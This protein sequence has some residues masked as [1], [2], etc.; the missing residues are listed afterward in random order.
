MQAGLTDCDNK[1]QDFT[2]EKAAELEES[3]LKV[4][5]DAGVAVN[6]ANKDA[7]IEASKPIYSQFADEVDGGQEMIDTV[8]GLGDAS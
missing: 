2:Y 3:L 1:T 7:F 6:I 4:I 8:L 5:E